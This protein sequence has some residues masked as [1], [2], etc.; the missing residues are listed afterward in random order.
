MMVLSRLWYIVLALAVGISMY[1]VFLAVGEYDRRNGVAMEEELASDSQTVGWALQIDSR[2]RLDALL[3]GAV[4]KG[5]QDSLQLATGR[6][7]IPQK[8]K[9]DGRHA[10]T[11]ALQKIPADFRPDALFEVDH[12]GRVVSQV[13][14]DSANAFPD[15]ELGGYPA[16]FDALHGYLRDDT[17]VLGGK[18]YRVDARPVE[19]DSTQP[20]LGAIVALRAVDKRFAEDIS[21]RTRANVA[22]FAGGQRVASATMP[23]FDAGS[24]TA[25]DSDMLTL[26]TDKGFAEGRSDLRPMGE[27][28][29]AIYARFVGDAWDLGAG[30][31]VVRAR[32]TIGGP[33]GFLN[34]ADDKDKQSVNLPLIGGVVFFAIVIGFLLS[35]LE[36]SRPLREMVKQSVALRGGQL[37][38]LQV[39]RFRGAYRGIADNVNAGIERVLERGGGAAR[40]PADLESIL[41]PVPSQPAMSAFSFPLP[42][43]GGAPPSVPQVPPA[44]AVSGPFAVPPASSSGPTPFAV[45]VAPGGAAAPGPGSPGSPA[46]PRAR[47]PAPSGPSAHA[48]PA[49]PGPSPRAS[50]AA[51][52]NAGPPIPLPASATPGRPPNVQ[53][54]LDDSPESID[55]D[56]PTMASAAAPAGLGLHMAGLSLPATPAAASPARPPSVPEVGVKLGMGVAAR[57]GAPAPIGRGTM[58]GI[59]LDGQQPASGPAKQ[60][61]DLDG[62]DESTVIARAPSELLAAASGPSKAIS[63]ETA[64]WMGVYDEFLRTKKQCDEPTEGLSFEKFQNTLRKNRD[65][66][67]QRHQ[68]KRVRFSVYVKDG[69]ASLKATPVKE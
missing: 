38:Y 41:G 55:G 17:W 61:L 36:H 22:F 53:F 43:G 67:V 44:R 46:F 4:D 54:A 56:G 51:F 14:F 21:K 30:F 40:K 9:D 19:V 39:A 18:V 28:L 34:G 12:D 69:R 47:P 52:P 3:I 62:E 32:T 16:V 24:L 29:G 64:E 1:V 23:A 31:V 60:P 63:A 57:P 27:N 10:L 58:M 66:L 59:G 7:V 15:F 20:P 2:K 65:A 11:A 33:L 25:V 42:E 49:N 45:P 5:V 8:A 37:D 50:N 68:C 48:P 13:G 35:M 26:G 6:D